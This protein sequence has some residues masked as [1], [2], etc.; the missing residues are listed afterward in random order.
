MS[1]SLN[2]RFQVLSGE[3]EMAGQVNNRQ[4]FLKSSVDQKLT[5]I[6]DDLQ[7]IRGEQASINHRFTNFESTITDVCK[8]LKQVECTSNA[9]A[10]FFKTLAYKSIDMEARARRNNIIFRG[11]SENRGDNCY[12]LVREFL[13]N[14][15]DIDSDRMY[16][17]RAHRL[18]RLQRNNQYQSRPIIV[19][20][21]DYCDIESIMNSARM[22]RGKPFSIDHDFPKEIQEARSRLWP[23]FKQ[24]RRD[25]PD[26]RVVLAYPAK[27]IKNGQVVRDELPNWQKHISANRI[28]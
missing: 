17:A 5:V 18:G 8:T 3:R 10:E 27:I 6:F 14:H 19:N 20:F 22:L 2:N 1:L 4:D 21:R 13:S 7:C 28:T 23:M 11:I 12:Q 24:L 25:A 9:N 16:I 15:L 26:A